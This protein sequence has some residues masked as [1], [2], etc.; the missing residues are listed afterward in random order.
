MTYQGFAMSHS[1]AISL[2]NS[3]LIP[4][5]SLAYSATAG[6]MLLLAAA[7]ESAQL[8]VPAALIL[9]LCVAVILLSLLHG[10]RHGSPGARKSVELLTRTLYAKWF[11]ALV[12]GAGVLLPLLLLWFAGSV[13]LATMIAAAGTLAGYY[14]FRL[15]IFKAGVFEPIM[16]FRP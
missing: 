3:G 1:T 10:A 9:H 14:T 11:F 15:L 12:C 8:M 13:P 2:W 7:P 6:V 16:S 4:V 5:S